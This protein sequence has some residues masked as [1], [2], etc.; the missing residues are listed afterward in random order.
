V[1]RGFA[2]AAVALMVAS[3]SGCGEGNGSSSSETPAPPPPVNNTQPVIVDAGPLVNGQFAG[4]EDILFT[5]VTICMPGT[6]TCQT[7]DHVMVD[8][9]STGLRIV[10]SQLTLNLPNS[11]NAS[12]QPIANCIQYADNTYQWGPVAK[13][14][15]KMAGEVASAV[16]IQV[17]GPANFPAPPN[18][19]TAGGTAAQTVSDLGANGILGVGLFRQDCGP[20]CAST[21]PPAVYFTCPASGCTS[22]TVS[23][24][25]QLQNPIWMFPQDNN[26]FLIVLPQVADSG[27]ASVAGSMIFGIGTQ[28]DNALGSAQAQAVDGFGN[29]TT[30]FNGTKYSGSF[31]D[32]GSNGM[33]F[34]DSATTG[35]PDCSRQESGFYCPS[36]TSSLT[37]INSG[38]SPTGSGTTVSANIAFSVAN[39]ATLFN[40]G[41]NAFNDVG[42]SNPGAFDWG[43]PF[44]FGRTVF[45][46]IEGQRSPA[47]TGP[48]W[49]Y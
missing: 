41:N 26:G 22:A 47:G 40:T 43:L 6:S 15:I 27:A 3:L 48:Y 12:G 16:P 32:S 29:F 42:G 1:R 30:T 10:A 18:D 46:G 19:C 33:F 44:F 39:A 2:A 25:E 5:S 17:V 23:V 9:G 24:T 21:S 38:P 28:S 36:A 34:L 45:V 13:A 20:A 7:I 31:I 49:A 11:L 14:D 8:T 35:L 37:A 4:N